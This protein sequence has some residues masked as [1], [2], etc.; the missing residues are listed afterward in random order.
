MQT[1]VKQIPTKVKLAILVLLAIFLLITWAVP[2]AGITIGLAAAIGWS[3]LT[4]LD[5]FVRL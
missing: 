5:Y 1:K 4:L 3:V 2:G